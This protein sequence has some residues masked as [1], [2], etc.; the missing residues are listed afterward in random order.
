MKTQ[1]IMF[2]FNELGLENSH[3]IEVTCNTQNGKRILSQDFKEDDLLIIEFECDNPIE[4]NDNTMNLIKDVQFY[5][6]EIKIKVDNVEGFLSSFKQNVWR[7]KINSYSIQLELTDNL[8]QIKSM[9]E[10]YVAIKQFTY[11]EV[12]VSFQFTGKMIIPFGG[13]IYPG[14]ISK[15]II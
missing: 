8:V 2:T 11:A 10:E 14:Y 7:G 15:V 9:N 6:N 1:K 4:S 13:I 12:D 3:P 5:P